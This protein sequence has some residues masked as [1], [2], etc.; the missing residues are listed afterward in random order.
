MNDYVA[1]TLKTVRKMHNLT[2]E[3]LASE[4]GISS[5]HVGMLEQGRGR[6]SHELMEKIIIKYN[7][8]ANMFFGRV[9]KDAS[10]ERERAMQ[11]AESLIEGVSEQLKSYRKESNENLREI[12]SG[13]QIEYNGEE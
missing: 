12:D 1:L 3:Q 11:L 2:Q 9:P 10:S 6:P 5:G 7:V 4:I 13:P 8:D